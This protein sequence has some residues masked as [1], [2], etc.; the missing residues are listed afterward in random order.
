M[1]NKL[2]LGTVQ[3]GIPYGINNS[4]GKPNEQEA[5]TI[6][7]SARDLRITTLDT[8]KAYGNSMEIIGNFH[9][10][11]NFTF[12]VVSK[13]HAGNVNLEKDLQTELSLLEIEKFEA[14]LFHSYSD[15]E[16][17]SDKLTGILA[18]LKRKDFINKI[19]VSV[20]SNEQFKKAIESDSIDIIQLPYNLLDN[21][22][23]RGHLIELAKNAGKELHV[24]SVFLQGLFFMKEELIPKKIQKLKPY[25][26]QIKELAHVHDFT[27][28]EL[29]LAYVLQNKMIDKVLIGVE[30]E[31][32][33]RHNISLLNKTRSMTNELIAKIES[34]NV[35]ETELLSPVNWN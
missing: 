3:L 17:A 27:L 9:R 18:D 14:Y 19:G 16:G 28:P 21:Y 4:T 32:Q 23:Q 10:K 7:A 35:K 20:Y 29:A 30:S 31:N 1:I 5:E 26:R 22:S 34:I 25:I 2:I 6:L 11:T 24:R 33:L 12:K 8:A 15:F 13:F